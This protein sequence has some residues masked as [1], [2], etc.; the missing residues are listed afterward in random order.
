MFG[1]TLEELRK[2]DVKIVMPVAG[3]QITYECKRDRM[4]QDTGNVAVEHK[5]IL[6]SQAEFIV[7]M[8]DGTEGLFQVGRETLHGLL[9]EN[10]QGERRWRVVRGG[11]YQDW[12]T[13]IPVGEFMGFC[14]EIDDILRSNVGLSKILG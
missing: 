7:Y 1:D 5:A 3:V 6:H 2:Y 11:Q 13:L 10:W 14:G 4:A 9:K 12:M 8:I